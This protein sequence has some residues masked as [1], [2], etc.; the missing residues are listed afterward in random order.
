MQ[1]KN[2]L[3]AI[4]ETPSH[5]ANKQMLQSSKTWAALGFPAAGPDR[6][7]ISMQSKG[8]RLNLLSKAVQRVHNINGNLLSNELGPTSPFGYSL[9]AVNHNSPFAY[10]P[11]HLSSYF[12]P[13]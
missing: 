5:N 8:V 12:M 2:L 1:R 11:E 7:L 6:S 13:E 10:L 4:P 3:P 9:H